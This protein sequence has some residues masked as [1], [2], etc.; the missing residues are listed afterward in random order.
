MLS[1]LG[2]FQTKVTEGHTVSG[3]ALIDLFIHQATAQAANAGQRLN[4]YILV[5][6]D[7]GSRTPVRKY[8][9]TTFSERRRHILFRFAAA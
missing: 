6:G 1:I 2:N 4:L 5:G 3:Q 9:H 7:E 8:C